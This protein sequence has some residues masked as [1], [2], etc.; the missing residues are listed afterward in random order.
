MLTPEQDSEQEIQRLV[1]ERGQIVRSVDPEKQ[2]DIKEFASTLVDQEFVLT[3]G[4]TRIAERQE[5]R[6]MNPLGVGLGLL[7][8]G[9]GLFIFI[10][11]VALV[12]V[13]SGLSALAGGL[14]EAQIEIAILES[15]AN[16][17]SHV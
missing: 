17:L 11:A 10:P 9:A 5:L 4:S 8:L 12:L 16:I 6:S 13:S 3:G 14:V 15:F 7:V 1:R 2:D